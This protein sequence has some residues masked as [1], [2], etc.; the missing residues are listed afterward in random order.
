[1][2]EM[3]VGLKREKKAE[4]KI[5]GWSYMDLA[6]TAFAGLGLE[7]LYAFFLEP[8]LYGASMQEWGAVQNIL[9]WILTCATWGLIAW[10]VVR[11]GKKQLQF[12]IWEKGEKV[13]PWQWAFVLVIVAVCI[14][15]NYRDWGGFQIVMEFQKKGIV[16][17]SFQYLYYMVETVLV[18]LIVVFGQKAMELWL[19]HKNIPWGGIVCGLTW[20]LAHAMTKG[21]LEMGLMGMLWG[22]LFG[23]A[24]LLTN[25]DCKKA[26]IFMLI[27]FVF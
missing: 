10:Y 6:I 12:D 15:I 27:M 19:Q 8:F 9:H 1:M 11:S 5:T 25:R 4:K 16:L 7:V 21:S 2:K 20:G 22:T 24:Y 26:Y 17:F 14:A 3:T 23:S 18:L 13:K